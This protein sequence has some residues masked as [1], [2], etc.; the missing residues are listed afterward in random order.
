MADKDDQGQDLVFHY[1]R[2]RRLERAPE[3]VRRLNSRLPF[4]KPNLFRTLTANKASAF[5]FLAIIML[6][7]T[8]LVT[9]FLVP[10]DDVG[11]LAGNKVSL[12]ALRFQG[13][14]YLALKKTARSAA[15]S[16]TVDLQVGPGPGEGDSI[17]NLSVV[18][19]PRED[20]EFR[21]AVPGERES[22][23]VV[24]QAAEE[25]IELKARVE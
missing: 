22:L 2:E 14:T 17:L 24:L 6:S 19:T 13:T 9:A 10:G 5:L 15:Y 21:L 11:T 3:E 23:V 8:T 16:G 18:F 4:R 12:T 1:S 20:E 7:L 25:R